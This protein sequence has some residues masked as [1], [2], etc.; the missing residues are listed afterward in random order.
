MG[1]EMKIFRESYM[2][3]H[4]FI[5]PDEEETKCEALLQLGHMLYKIAG[6]VISCNA[7]N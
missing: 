1:L 5:K 3:A 6:L 2:S 7:A 4:I